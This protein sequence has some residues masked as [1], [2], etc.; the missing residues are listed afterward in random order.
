MRANSKQNGTIC[1][2]IFPFL[3]LA[4]LAPAIGS[5]WG[6]GGHMMVAQIAYENLN[7]TARTK[8]NALFETN[9]TPGSTNEFIQASH[10][11]DDVKHTPAF[12]ST[13]DEHFVDFPFSPDHTPLPNLPKAVNVTNALQ[14]YVQVLKDS[15]ASNEAQIVAA[16]FIIHL[17]GDVHQPLHCATRVTQDHPQGDQG[18]NAFP[19]HDPNKELHSLWDGGLHQFPKELPGFQPPPV[20]EVFA[21]VGTLKTNFSFDTEKAN[22]AKSGLN[23]GAWAQESFGFART[24][25]YVGIAENGKPDSAYLQNLQLAQ[26]RVI[27][28][29][30]RLAALLNSI[31]PETQ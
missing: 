5:A 9:G 31:W 20:E 2:S 29:G 7:P 14:K 8:V 27:W 21:A 6:D 11:P 1:S 15:S 23:Y 28:A 18:G 22:T 30:F 19:I 13:A 4:L 25:A 17:V 10:W 16:K 12:A 3:L 24:N 26:R